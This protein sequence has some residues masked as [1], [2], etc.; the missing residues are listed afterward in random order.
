[1]AHH[2]VLEIC[3]DSLESAR[4]ARLG[5]ADRLELCAALSLGGL[6]PSIGLLTCVK[7]MLEKTSTKESAVMPVFVMIRPREG[8][9][10]YEDDELNVMERD[11]TALKGA[12]ADGFVFG[13]LRPDC[14]VNLD[15]C[16]RLLD[17]AQPLPCTFHRYLSKVLGLKHSVSS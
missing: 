6:T 14:T 13:A 12:G 17:A 9:F 7:G 8:D 10:V 16:R 2:Q 1:M 11:I 15:A 5:G 3:V 4:N